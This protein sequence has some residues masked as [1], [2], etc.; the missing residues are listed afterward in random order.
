MSPW[1]F[2]AIALLAIVGIYY[3]MLRKRAI[4]SEQAGANAGPEVK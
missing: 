3:A 1:I 2:C 4:P